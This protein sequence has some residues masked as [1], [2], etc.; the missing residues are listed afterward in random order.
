MM[1][2]GDSKANLPLAGKG[3]FVAGGAGGLGRAMVAAFAEQGAGV[4]VADLAD[5]S[6]EG[7]EIARQLPQAIGVRLDVR[8]SASIRSAIQDAVDGLGSIDVVVCNAGL[9]VRKPTL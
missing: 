2:A 3:A 6:G 9:N 1:Q 4:A 7:G 8:D 5:R